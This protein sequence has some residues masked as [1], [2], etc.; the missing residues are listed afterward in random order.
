MYVVFLDVDIFY[1]FIELC[2][3]KWWIMTKIQEKEALWQKLSKEAEGEEI[4]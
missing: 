4:C 3:G 2:V 1:R